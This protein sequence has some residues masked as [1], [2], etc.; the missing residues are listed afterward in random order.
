MPALEIT[1]GTM[2][3]VL[4]LLV[5]AVLVLGILAGVVTW[6]VTRRKHKRFDVE[7]QRD[8]S[9]AWAGRKDVADLV[10]EPGTDSRR[11]P[12][13]WLDTP[14]RLGRARSDFLCTKEGTSTLILAP[15]QAGKTTRVLTRAA[16]NHLGPAVIASVKPDLFQLSIKARHERGPIWLWDPTNS[17]GHD[18]CRWSLIA[19]I[20]SWDDAAYAGRALTQAASGGGD[21]GLSDKEFWRKLAA[22][23]LAPLLYRAAHKEQTLADVRTAVLTADK[24]EQTIADDLDRYGNQSA[25]NAWESYRHTEEK[26]KGSIRVSAQQILEA[27]GT[28]AIAPAMDIY[29]AEG[30]P[31]FS[32]DEFLDSTGTL[33]VVAPMHQQELF[34]PIYTVLISAIVTRVEQRHVNSGKPLRPRLLMCLDETGNTA[35]LRELDKVAS[36]G[37]GQGMIL[38]TTWQDYAQLVKIYGREVAG[39]LW[40]NH[41]AKMVL[42]GISDG[43]TLERL[44]KLLGKIPVKML[45]QNVSE[46]GQGSLNTSTT[47]VDL[48]PEAAIR[49]LPANK[50]LCILGNHDPMI[51]RVPAWYE[52]DELRAR[53]DADIAAELERQHATDEPDTSHDERE[54]TTV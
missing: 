29:S 41:G 3:T 42:P 49:K 21:S 2:V 19:D 5:V 31:V 37:A 28:D 18:T 9:A 52:D 43:A 27:W 44:S 22:E 14:R 36:A 30:G 38:M 54:L 26:P 11:L 50:A 35:P 33:Y 20:H 46:R 40:S 39:V 16:V 48:K 1:L 23:M 34:Q 47:E 24:E 45:N 13:G 32:I 4:A 7:E 8:E 17:T 25:V 12:L 15:T 53:I 6:L 10:A 51:L